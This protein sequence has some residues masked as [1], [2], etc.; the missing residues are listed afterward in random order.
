MGVGKDAAVDILAGTAG[1]FA[2]VVAGHPLDTIKVRLQTQQPGPDGKLPF[3]GMVDCAKKTF[4]KEGPAGLYKG[5]ASP[6]LGAM[7]HN[8]AVFFSY[9]QAKSLTGANV[10]GAELYKYFFAG[11][12]AAVAITVVETPVDLL[13]IKLQSQVGKGEYNGVF[14]AAGK[15][16]KA[17]GIRGLYQGFSAT[18]LRNVPCFGLYFMGSEFGYR[19]ACKPGETHSASQVFIGGLVGGACAGGA[20]WGLPYPLETIKTRMQSDAIEH[21]KRK[22]SGILDCAKKTYVSICVVVFLLF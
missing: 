3:N 5:A 20:F 16:S 7:A 15:L 19:L 2:Q 12:I 14:D 1:G 8:A 9:G 6:L 10:T 13:K 22:Y 17:H 11:S 18:M 4:A 21:S